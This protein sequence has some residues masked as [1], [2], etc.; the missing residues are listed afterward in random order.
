M[1]TVNP[2]LYF[3]GNCEAAFKFYASVFQK[4]ISH[5]NKYKDVPKSQRDIFQEPDAKIMHATLPI[6]K[7]TML[8]GADHSIAYQEMVQHKTYY[9]IIHADS[10]EEVD[11]LFEKLSDNG[12]I[13][14]PVGLTFWGAY[15]GQ[16]IDQFGISWKI[17]LAS[18]S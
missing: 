6:G 15:Y 12:E 10:K 2:Y 9:L 11:R 13:V 3:D 14:V 16:C 8:N 18:E 17:T 5:I 7:D 1:A 4:E